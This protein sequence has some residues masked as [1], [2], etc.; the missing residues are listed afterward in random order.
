MV[1]A[2]S[3]G[4]K[5]QYGA[6]G[7]RP[8]AVS[9]STQG[10]ER[11]GKI[12]REGR[13]KTDAFAAARMNEGQGVGVQHLARGGVAGQIS[14]TLV[15]AV[16]VSE[17]ADQWVAEKLKMHA[18]LVSAARVKENFGVSRAA[19]PFEHAITGASFASGFFIHGHSFAVRGMP[20]NGGSDLPAIALNLAANDGM[21]NFFHFAA[22]ELG[23]KG[24][25][26][27]V[28]FRDHKAT[29]GFFI[30]AV[31]NS[32]PSNAADAAEFAFTM[33]QQGIYQR[34]LFMAESGMDDESRRLV[35]DQQRIIFVDDFERDFFGLRFRG[36]RFG[37]MHFYLFADARRVGR[38]YRAAI[39]FDVALLDQALDRAA[40]DCGKFAAQEC[41]EPFRRQRFFNGQDFS[42]RTHRLRLEREERTIIL[43]SPAPLVSPWISARGHFSRS[44]GKPIL[45][46]CK[47]RYQ[48]C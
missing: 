16:A 14:Q 11:V 45:L 20:A 21:I 13:L 10:R 35:H 28:V 24:E 47:W 23:G 17:I 7:S 8:A 27:V 33:M 46:R 1:S 2:A 25:M 36:A 9:D 30:K 29:A 34:V 41:V 26:G 18:D 48:Q 43:R 31:D 39:Y 40:R 22:G 3:N 4:D 19:K 38:F 44:A 42:A 37:P 32:R 5:T 6:R 15:L 12:F